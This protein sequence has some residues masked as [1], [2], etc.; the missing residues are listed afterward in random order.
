MI[1]VDRRTTGLTQAHAAG[2][3]RLSA[4]AAAPSTPTV[5][6]SLLP[7]STFPDEIITRIKNSGVQIQPGLSD[8]EF[9]RVE[10]EFGFVFLPDL[11]V[12]LSFG[13]SVDAG[14]PDW[15]SPGARRHLRA[16]IDLPNAAVSLQVAKNSLWCKSWGQR[17]KE[18]HRSIAKEKRKGK[19]SS[20][21]SHIATYGVITASTITEY[22]TG[23]VALLH[24]SFKFFIFLV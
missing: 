13:L 22:R 11:R 3:R 21:Q 14:F 12:I 6:N 24:F 15:R 17:R 1:G 4:R 18:R 9:A 23:S 20:S 2:L 10:A 19:L 16:M 8:S 5:R 7:F